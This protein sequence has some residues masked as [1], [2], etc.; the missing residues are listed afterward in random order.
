MPG[1]DVQ[2]VAANN[3]AVDMNKMMEFLRALKRLRE[4]GVRSN[5]YNIAHPFSRSGGATPRKES[6]SDK[7]LQH[8]KR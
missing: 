3:K 6:A 2:E 4:N 5:G 7:R 8:L 1:V